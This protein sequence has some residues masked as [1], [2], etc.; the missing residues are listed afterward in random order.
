MQDAARGF[1]RRLAITLLAG[2]FGLASVLMGP[3][4][5]S[6]AQAAVTA[7]GDAERLT[8]AQLAALL[9]PIALFPD[10]LLMQVLMAATYPLEIVQAARWLAQGQN[11]QLRAEALAEALQAQPWDPSVKSLLPFPDLLRMLNERLEWTQGLGDAVLAQ[12]QDVLNMV[13]VLRG[14]AHAMEHLQTNER[15]VI[16]VAP[17]EGKVPSTTMMVPP[18]PQIITI[19]PAEPD[20]VFVPVYNPGVVYGRWP[21]PAYPPVYVAPPPAWGLSDTMLTGIAFAGG[22][23][24]VGSLWGWARP[25]WRRGSVDVNVNRF[26]AINVNRVQI[27]SNVWRHDVT[28]RGGLA[29]RNAEVN[30]RFRGEVS[31]GRAGSRDEFRGR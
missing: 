13:Q 9:A 17:L 16:T 27:H 30:S 24:I 12:Q 26:N 23:A 3:A 25:G 22:A 14:R 18:P 15:Q 1:G 31:G 7:P 20:L 4:G 29:Y 6:L 11:G 8:Q 28:H 2:W 19:A 21:Y 5:P 10:E